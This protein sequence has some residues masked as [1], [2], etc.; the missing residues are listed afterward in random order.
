MARGAILLTA[1]MAAPALL[2]ASLKTTIQQIGKRA[3]RPNDRLHGA[4]VHFS[5]AI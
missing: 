2:R 3:D 1:G 4:W 5:R